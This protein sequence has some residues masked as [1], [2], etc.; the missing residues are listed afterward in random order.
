[1]V[2]EVVIV[3]SQRQTTLKRLKRIMRV[4]KQDS[5]S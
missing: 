4:N 1:M 3:R 2:A 5:K